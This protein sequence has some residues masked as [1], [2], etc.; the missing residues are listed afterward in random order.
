MSVV[1]INPNGAST[2]T[3]R[4]TNTGAT[5]WNIRVNDERPESEIFTRPGLSEIRWHVL[6][7]RSRQEKLIARVL[8]SAGIR[9]FLPLVR[10]VRC[11]GHRHRVVEQPLFACYLFLYGTVE[12]T[13]LATATKRIVEVIGVADQQR[14]AHELQQI[15]RAVAHGAELALYPY[16][17]VGR[18][19]RVRAGPFRGIEGL[20]EDSRKPSRLVLQ[21]QTLGRAT[22]VEI[23]AGLLEQVD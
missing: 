19:V 14:V 12:D 1:A 9:H 6:R 13:Y 17:H 2:R 18:R 3:N 22:S 11:Y 23:D 8:R 7:T 20:V 21:V 16:L 4:R 15:Q 10:R 5:G